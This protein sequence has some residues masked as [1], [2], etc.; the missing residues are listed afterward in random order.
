ML[1]IVGVVPNV[2]QA[3]PRQPGVDT[4]S[5]EPVLYRT[6][7]ANPP[8]SATILVRSSV[9][10]GT[11]A[12]VLRDALR[13]IDA[14]LPLAGSVMPLDEAIDQELGLL[15]VFASMLGLFALV[16]AMGLAMV[17]MYGVTA[18]AVTLRTR[19]LGIRLALGAGTG[20]HLVDGDSPGGDPVAGRR[21]AGDWR[22]AECGCAPSGSH[23]GCEQPRP[24]HAD[25]RHN[26]HDCVACVACLVPAARAFVSTPLR[27]CARNSGFR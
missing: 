23:I 24:G 22:C 1:T 12:G 25:R 17:G 20:A 5:A 21:L 10:P 26:A 14:D 19:E 4:N 8:P 6:Y 13:A 27:L 18:H 16:A 3:S 2:R 7:A 9:G 15:T 11:V